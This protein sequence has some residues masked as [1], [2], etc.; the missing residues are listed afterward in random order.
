MTARKRGLGDIASCLGLVLALFGLTRQKAAAFQTQELN[1]AVREEKKLIAFGYDIFRD[2][3]ESVTEGPIN[4]EYVL[5]PADEIIIT[6]WGQLNLKYPLLVSEDG[7]I[8]IPDEGGRVYTNGVSLKELRRL[9]TESLSRIYASYV[10]AQNPAQSTAFVDVKLA[11][12]RKLLVYVVGE[13]KNQGPYSINSGAATLLNL[14]NNAGGIMETGTLR[15]IRIR[16]ANGSLDSVDLY[17]FLITGKAD[18]QK[19]QMRAGDYIMVPLKGKSV[20]L[21][22][23]VKREG[24]YEIIGNEGVKD[25]LRYAGGLTFN[26]YLKRVQI[27]RSEMNT[28][29]RFIELD[30]E[31]IFQDPR[32][33]FLLQDG[34]EV[35]FFPNVVIRRPFVEVQGNGVKR[36]GVYQYR[37]GMT[38]R[39]LIEF[40]EGLRAEAYLDR[41]YL[42]RTEPDFSRQLKIFSLKDLYQK[43]PGGR[44]VIAGTAERNFPLQELDVVTT[45]SSYEIK[46]RDKSVKL[47]GHVKE[48][49]EYILAENM[50]L[51]DLIFARGGFQDMEFMKR[52]FLGLAHIFRKITGDIEEK[53]LTFNL[54][55]L[56]AGQASENVGLEAGDRIVIYSFEE[57]KT[58][59][60]VTIEGL[61][62][63]PGTYTLAEGLTL[64]D[65]I[66]VAG[67]LRPDAY[68]TEAVIA[69]TGRRA[70]G[71][72]RAETPSGKAD[73]SAKEEGKSY[74]P[75]FV[76]PVNPDYATTAFDKKTKLEIFDKIVIRNLPDWE[77]LPII[78]IEGQVIFPGGYSLPSREERL[79]QGIKLAGGLKKEAFPEGAVLLR[80]KDIVEMSSETQAGIL[81]M[82]INLKKALDNP[83][84]PDDLIMKNGDILFIPL[85]P[86]SVQVR[87]AVKNPG[88]FQYR[89]GRTY[90]YYLDLSG[91]FHKEADNK[92]I[93]VF[94]PNGMAVRRG[95]LGSNP[96]I[97]PGSIIDVPY[98]G[99]GREIS[100]VEIRGAVKNPIMIQPRKGEKLDYYIALAGGYR[101]DADIANIL[102][103]LSDGQTLE[104]RGVSLFNP[105]IEGQSIV[106]IP[107][108][109]PVPAEKAEK[110]S[111]GAEPVR[112]G[113]VEIRGA[114]RFPGVV[115]FRKDMKL[116]YYL[117]FCGGLSVNADADAI[118]L[119]LPDGRVI[120]KV[121]EKEREAEKEK[122]LTAVPLLVPG[123]IVEVPFK[124][125]RKEVI[126]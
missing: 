68:K 23:E 46:G 55:N 29:E 94:M 80:R 63:K 110:E 17:E 52:A 113:D 118:L 60:F 53:V 32:K 3:R 44:Y 100:L 78:T 11:K 20:T 48:P 64:E 47:E 33:N 96:D 13:V 81:K 82:S 104:R 51:Y 19:T 106:E 112:F 107:F 117:N 103:H 26:A 124:V 28:G 12:V 15:D 66:L 65:L 2:L 8:E 99:E 126:K 108:K 125:E 114:V 74:I 97:L 22:G 111:Q 91:G 69:R 5:S 54:E 116:D 57:M 75:T 120:E 43:D 70:P 39:D 38:I 83:G 121:L 24:V 42:M 62:K 98:K 79:S 7:F 50:T 73:I 122:K 21:R 56:L 123:S 105:I 40:A 34:D 95:F 1:R 36:P 31:P 93:V 58:K 77:P 25:L 86:G 67:G 37:E 10:N 101:D 18:P 84:G 71:I 85:N 102:V 87:G 61:I 76:V 59:P 109:S 41:A 72:S 45:F 119:H 49:G 9:V 27:R 92:N 6:V 4:E 88:V 35:T 90:K 89:S 16:R 115:R 30:G 14:L